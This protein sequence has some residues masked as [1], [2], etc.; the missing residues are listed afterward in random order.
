V[1]GCSSLAYLA[2][3]CPYHSSLLSSLEACYLTSRHLLRPA[4][5][6]SYQSCLWRKLGTQRS[7]TNLESHHR[8]RRVARERSTP[9]NGNPF[10]SVKLPS[11]TSLDPRRSKNRL[12]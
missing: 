12:W 9:T 10:L 5:V 8:G 4:A 1:N 11:R 7:T 6:I 2:S 3:P